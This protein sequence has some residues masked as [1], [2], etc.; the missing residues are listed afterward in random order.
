MPQGQLDLAAARAPPVRRN[1]ANSSGSPAARTPRAAASRSYPTRTKST[2]TRPGVA[3]IHARAGDEARA[4]E[5]LER[6]LLERD[7]G[8]VYLAAD[9]EWERMRAAPR[10]KW[11]LERMKLVR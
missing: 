1:S 8:L 3:Q 10:V 9:P 2:L 6:A 11:L 5:W 4:L 7:P